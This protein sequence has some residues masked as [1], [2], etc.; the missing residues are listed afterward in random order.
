MTLTCQVSHQL[1]ISDY[2]SLFALLAV[3]VA[4]HKNREQIILVRDAFMNGK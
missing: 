1:S 4:W 3:V 2:L